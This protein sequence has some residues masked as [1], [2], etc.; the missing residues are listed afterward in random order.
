[1]KKEL[2]Q[3]EL[4][5]LY[6]L[7]ALIETDPQKVAGLLFPDRPSNRLSLTEAIGQWAINQ[8][9]ALEN[10]E[11]GKPDVAVVFNKVGNRIWQRLPEH[12]Q[13]VR[14]TIV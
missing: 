7:S 10:S 5:E 2:R 8:A 13:R 3:L 4:D 11:N 14:I 6:Q 12:A 9:V 1:M